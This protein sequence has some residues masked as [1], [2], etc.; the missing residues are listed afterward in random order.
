MRKRIHGNT[1]IIQPS[2]TNQQPI[3]QSII[4]S[5][6]QSINQ[7]STKMKHEDELQHIVQMIFLPTNLSYKKLQNL[8]VCIYSYAL[9]FTMIFAK[10]LKTT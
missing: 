4:Q 9:K 8:L 6:N 7:S 1:A 2:P 10:L 5:T 3:N